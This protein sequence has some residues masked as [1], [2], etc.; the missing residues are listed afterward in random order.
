MAGG[1]IGI[2]GDTEAG[3]NDRRRWSGVPNV[4]G[5]VWAKM[6]LLTVTMLGMQIVWSVEMGYASPYLLSL[7]LSKSWISMV[8]VAG[9][10]SGLIMQ[11]V[12]GALSDRSTSRFGRRRPF[13]L[14]GCSIC[15]ASLLLLGYTNDF[16]LIFGLSDMTHRRLTI[17][18]AVLS[19]YLIDFSINAVMAADRALLVDTLPTEEQELGNAWAGRMSGAGS[20][21]GF[22]IGNVS[23]PRL[24]PFLG[25]TQLEVL[26][27]LSGILLLTTH[28]LTIWTVHER[29]LMESPTDTRKPSGGSLAT[30]KEIWSNILTLPRVVLQICIIQFLSWIGWFPV[31]FY[32][33]LWISDIYY[34]N[35]P[36]SMSPSP[37]FYWLREESPRNGYEAG[38][39]MGNTALLYSSILAMAG[40]IFLPFLVTGTSGIEDDAGPWEATAGLGARSAVRTKEPWWKIHICTLWTISQAVFA[41]SMAATWFTST[42]TAASIII[43][44]T[45]FSWSVSLW[46]PFALLGEAIHSSGGPRSS[47]TLASSTDPVGD[48]SEHAIPLQERSRP[49]MRQISDYP[50]PDATPDFANLS[51]RVSHTNLTDEDSTPVNTFQ[52][53]TRAAEDEGFDEDAGFLEDPDTVGKS[54]V[55]DK[56]GVILGIHNIFI[57]VPQF[58]VTGLSAVVFAL[59]DSP[60]SVSSNDTTSFPSNSTTIALLQRDSEKQPFD[61][62]GL[63]FRIGG[64]SAAIACI[65][66]HRLS[67]QLQRRLK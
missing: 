48:Y 11:P 51:A 6:P 53:E 58:L 9:P 37:R 7:G 41:I 17:A 65:L 36:S 66:C 8:F 67:K 62:I 24:F 2:I 28:G 1:G 45:G 55:S 18:L 38:T 23:L 64:V 34:R 14:L 25:N 12:I 3:H 13:I 52:F 15:F 29:V 30:V 39:L 44:A 4:K 49:E 27:A 57:V 61:S 26:S 19:I 56:A 50:A 42:V 63:M 22:F 20:I 46:A 43:A 60:S 40:F 5:P 35:L 21:A 59:S 10:L 33:T 47:Y 16:T 32:T 31:L 54:G